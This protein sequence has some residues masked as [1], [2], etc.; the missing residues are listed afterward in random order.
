MGRIIIAA[1]ILA[2]VASGFIGHFWLFMSLTA[3][4]LALVVESEL[5]VERLRE[6][7]ALAQALAGSERKAEPQPP[8]SASHQTDRP[9]A[10]IHLLDHW[11]GKRD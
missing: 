4:A 5:R 9:P 8:A 6:R 10:E 2:V 3:L 11:R 7:L 1:A